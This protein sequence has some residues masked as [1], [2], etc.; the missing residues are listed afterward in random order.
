M[1]DFSHFY[2]ND[3]SLFVFFFCCSL[4]LFVELCKTRWLLMFPCKWKMKWK[5]NS[6][7][8]TRGMSDK[9]EKNKQRT[10]TNEN[11]CSYHFEHRGN[12]LT[13][14]NIFNV[15][16]S[17]IQLSY[18]HAYDFR[19]LEYLINFD[20]QIPALLQKYKRIKKYRKKTEK[21][22]LQRASSW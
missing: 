9:E 15:V 22:I 5:H 21:N 18:F 2:S 14:L 13:V 8:E 7:Y 1:F 6:K 11:I 17:T 12:L 3:S 10:I 4:T 20:V 19:E 16:Y